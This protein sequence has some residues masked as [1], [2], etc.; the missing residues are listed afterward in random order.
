M[1]KWSK[2]CAL[3]ST[4]LFIQAITACG[5]FA[6]QDGDTSGEGDNPAAT[7]QQMQPE[8][9][10]TEQLELPTP[11]AEVPPT[12]LG[13]AAILTG[14]GEVAEPAPRLIGRSPAGTATLGLNESVEL[15]FDQPMNPNVTGDAFAFVDED[16]EP[17][18]G[19]IE[20]PQPRI[21]RFTPEQVLTIGS[22]Y[23]VI[24]NESAAAASGMTLVEAVSLDLFTI[25]DLEVNSVSPA[26]NSTDVATDSAVTV[27]FSLSLIHI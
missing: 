18:P 25:G 26:D 1:K 19:R 6:P 8:G 22:Q 7:V 15:F 17:I 24:L 21:L 3:L 27:I 10:A 23:N 2:A 13:A 4:I 5:Y 14:L 11:T 20:W 16:G 9:E 12:P